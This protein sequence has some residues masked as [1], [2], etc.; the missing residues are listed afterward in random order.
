MIRKKIDFLTLITLVT[1]IRQDKLNQCYWEVTLKVRAN[2]LILFNQ[3]RQGVSS[4]LMP[5]KTFTAAL[6]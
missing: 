5:Q 3:G 1:M 6:T 2:S 4:G